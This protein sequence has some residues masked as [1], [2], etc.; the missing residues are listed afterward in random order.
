[1]KQ[2]A[3]KLITT[4]SDGLMDVEGSGRGLFQSTIARALACRGSDNN[5]TLNRP[6]V[7]M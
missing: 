1:V 6:T 7:G 5:T 3:I 2:H 4:I